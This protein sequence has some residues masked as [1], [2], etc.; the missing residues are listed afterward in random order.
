FLH[1]DHPTK[2]VPIARR[3]S[4]YPDEI[5]LAD[6]RALRDADRLLLREGKKPGASEELGGVDAVSPTFAGWAKEHADA[7]APPK[8]RK[9]WLR[10]MT[11]TTAKFG[12]LLI[13]E[14]K[15]TDVKAL[16]QP[17]WYATPTQAVVIC[18]RV[19][20]VLKHRHRNTRPDEPFANPADPALIGDMMGRRR[21][22]ITKHHPS[23]AYE[24]V[25]AFM[26]ELRADPL[27]SARIVE[28]AI[29]T[30]VRIGKEATHARWGEINWQRRTWT[31]PASR[32]KMEDDKRGEAH[33]VPITPGMARLL[34]QV[35]PC[36]KPNPKSL[37]FPSA[38]TGKAYTHHAVWKRV[39]RINPTVTTHGFRTSLVGWGSAIPHGPYPPFDRELME[40]CIAHRIGGQTSAAYL[41]DRWLARRRPVMR[42][43]SKWCFPTRPPN[44]VPIRRAA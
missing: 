42:A 8:G 29:L 15:A 26:A 9:D 10:Q 33:E 20:R 2:G 34:R 35:R 13:D 24:E 44:I 11:V 32:M 36:R 21:K 22:H 1:A 6:A 19:S 28:W 31:V 12:T 17:Y 16:L 3:S 27:M 40:T 43:W 23:L 25:P 4:T 5:S 39:K 7:L 18:Q 38:Q 37:I 41:R 14:I 30:G